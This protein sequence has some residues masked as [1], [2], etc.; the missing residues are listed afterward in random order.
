MLCILKCIRFY[1]IFQVDV[2]K[3]VLI[4]DDSFLTSVKDG[5]EIPLD[6][7]KPVSCWD[8]VL[9]GVIE[10]IPIQI[11]VAP[12]LVCTEAAQT[13]GGGDNISSAGLVL[14]V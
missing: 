9:S 13:A 4:L 8:E 1:E 11:C 14:Q 7:N 5:T 2:K 10:K 6:I 12:G 3:A